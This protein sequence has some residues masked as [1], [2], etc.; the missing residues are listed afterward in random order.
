MSALK[1]LAALLTYP[2]ADLQAAMPEIAGLLA[3]T[4]HL[5]APTRAGL[6]GLTG[7]M[8]RSDLM[9]LQER[10]V[11]LFDRNRR[12]SLHLF[13][14]V[15]GES[16][17]RG[18]AMVDLVETY[19]RHGLEVSARELPDYLPLFLEFLSLLPWEEA[20]PLL[21]DAGQVT[22]VIESRLAGRSSLYAAVLGAL[23]ELAGATAEAAPEPARPEEEGLEAL[24]RAWEE[25]AVTFGPQAPGAGG[26]CERVSAVLERMNA[27]D[28]RMQP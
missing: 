21:A 23:R 28:G 18:M 13:E 10:Y 5:S 2:E 22:N 24:D 3:A 6:E 27:L 15:H 25:A 14:H 9:E 26:G 1:A 11:D 7:A 16:R 4:P 20:R 12:L 17:D 8:A 19:R